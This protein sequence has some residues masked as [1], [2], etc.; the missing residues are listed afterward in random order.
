[1]SLRK[2]MPRTRDSVPGKKCEEI[3]DS[4]IHLKKKLPR[5]FWF[6][7]ISQEKK[8]KKKSKRKSEETMI[9]QCVSRKE[10]PRNCNSPIGLKER[11]AK[12]EI[13][14]LQSVWRKSA[15][16]ISDA[17]IR[18]ELEILALKMTPHRQNQEWERHTERDRDGE[19]SKASERA[20]VKY[21]VEGQTHPFCHSQSLAAKEEEEEESVFWEKSVRYS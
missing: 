17:P 10:V 12:K 16:K 2:K 1:M 9:L 8:G 21:N 11:R 6:S 7:N 18:I 20:R 19:R 15:K 13:V 5:N 14:I 3:C 4:L